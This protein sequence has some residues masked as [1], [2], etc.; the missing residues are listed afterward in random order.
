MKHSFLS[1]ITLSVIV[2]AS[3]L[4]GCSKKNDDAAAIDSARD[5]N[6]AAEAQKVAPASA[7]TENKPAGPVIKSSSFDSFLPSI[8][9]YTAGKPEHV[10]MNMNGM[11]GQVL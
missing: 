8:S 1:S 3:L 6:I 2:S 5:A 7:P 9:G 10:D 11:S 4:T